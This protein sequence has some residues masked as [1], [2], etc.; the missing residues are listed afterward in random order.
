L[1]FEIDHVIALKHDG[2][3]TAGN[4]ALSCNY[5]NSFKGSDIAGLDPKS[6]KLIRLFYPRLHR[7]HYHFCWSGPLLLGRTAIGRTTVEL[8]QINNPL[9]AEQRRSLILAGLFPPEEL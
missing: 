1:P 7:W 9:R 6:G 2:K 5:D 3:T 4:L 8:L